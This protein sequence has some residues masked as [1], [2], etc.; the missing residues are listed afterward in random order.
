MLS[1]EKNSSLNKTPLK[2]IDDVSVHR[3]MH[4]FPHYF[5]LT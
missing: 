4:L 3:R 1:T 5:E 2:F